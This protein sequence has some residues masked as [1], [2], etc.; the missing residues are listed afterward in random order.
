MKFKKPNASSVGSTLGAA[1]G[2]AVGAMVSNGVVGLIPI[3]HSVGKKALVAVAAA[4]GAAVIS[5]QDTTSEVARNL[6]IGMAG[7]Q[8]KNLVQE[9]AKPYAPDSKFIK[10]ALEVQSLP[11]PAAAAR[12]MGK[13]LG[14]GMGSP[15]MT[16]KLQMGQIQ[17]GGF[18][19]QV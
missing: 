16:A 8:V 4:V 9:V 11:A 12:A 2:I 17:N 19:F 14:R 5:G 18:T 15:E 13:A 6:C 10:D 1:A 3:D 7:Q